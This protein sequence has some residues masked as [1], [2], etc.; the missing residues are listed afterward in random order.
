MVK[1]TVLDYLSEFRR[2]PRSIGSFAESGP[3]LS[4]AMA[5]AANFKLGD[6]VVEFGP[7][8][9]VIT[10]QLLAHGVSPS[11]LLLIEFNQKFVNILRMRFPHLTILHAD[12]WQIEKIL[13]KHFPE[14]KCA[15]IVSSLP[16]LNFPKSQRVELMAAVDRALD[17]E[18]GRFVQF[19]YGLKRPVEAASGFTASPSKWIIKNVPP[20]RVWT[21]VRHKA[22]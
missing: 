12:A 6:I 3:Q 4:A 1:I 7:G 18:H 15:A 19:S 14:K 8:T 10:A 22:D 17:P 21:Y 5:K 11:Q 20:A 9:G 16:L 2:S 13:E